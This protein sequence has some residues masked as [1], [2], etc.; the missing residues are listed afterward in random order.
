MASLDELL[1]EGPARA[2]L[3]E[4]LSE[5]V[6]PASPGAERSSEEKTGWWKQAMSQGFGDTVHGPAQLMQNVL[7]DSVM[8]VGR[9]AAASVAGAIPGVPDEFAEDLARPR[10][11]SEFNERERTREADYQ[12]DRKEAGREGFDWWRTAGALTNPVGWMTPSSEA[13]TLVQGIKAGA[14]TGAFQAL[15]QPV[16]SEGNFLWDKA[17]QGGMG[18]LFGG[19]LSGAMMLLQPALRFGADKLGKVIGQDATDAAID[20]AAEQVTAN[21]TKTATGGARVNPDLYSAIRQEVGDA[22]RAGVP[23]SAEVIT[24]RAD[25][26]ALPVPVH[27]TRAQLTR[28]PMQWAWEHRVSGQR[29]VGEP[30]SE[31][32]SGQNK[33]LIQNLNELGAARATTPYAASQS[34]IGHLQ[35]VDEQ[36][37]DGINKAYAEVR[38]SAGRPAA[39]SVESFAEKAKHNLTEGRPDLAHLVNLGDTLAKD[40]PAIANTYNDIVQGKVPLTVDTAQWLDRTWGEVQRGSS[41][42]AAKAIGSLRRA[43]NDADIS[44]TLGQESMQAYK[45]ARQMAAQRFGLIDSNPAFKQVVE[46]KAEPDKFF[47]KFVDGA[48]VSE[49]QGLKKLIGP[50]LTSSLQNVF[51]DELKRKALSNASDEAGTFSQA[52]YNRVMQDPVRQPRIN[53]LFAD[54][55]K[56]LDQLYRVGRVA[57]GLIKP[58]AAAR[59]NT[60]NTA[61]ETANIVRDIARSETGGFLSSLLPNW[62]QGVGRVVSKGAEEVK[63]AQAVRDAVKPGVT[64]A[65]LPRRGQPEGARRLSDLVARGTGAAAAAEQRE[66]ERP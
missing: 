17:M 44:D 14:K 6:S 50:E 25:A 5:P 39:M 26:G 33:A 13:A 35:K 16:A 2:S 40:A 51:V 57:E 46:G 66:E 23:P 59:V 62:I 49:L 31:L 10:S 43:L 29:G 11:T 36:M 9:K 18:A 58:P 52:A 28:D 53:E 41:P 27:M 34:V 63:Q 65:P 61:V 12:A 64:A 38:N 60:S 37:R 1:E 32:L 22:M 24:R 55:P 20:Q 30:L 45:A 54:N 48:N 19:T 7:P 3:D 8:N 47:Q 21:V 15:L 4:L 56:T 42:A